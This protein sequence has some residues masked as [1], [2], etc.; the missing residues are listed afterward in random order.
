MYVLKYV[1][2]I[3]IT[4]TYPK[5][6]SPEKKKKNMSFMI[7]LPKNHDIRWQPNPLQSWSTRACRFLQPTWND[8]F[9]NQPGIFSK[10]TIRGSSWD[11]GPFWTLKTA[12]KKLGHQ[13]FGGTF[14]FCSKKLK[15]EPKSLPGKPSLDWYSEKPPGRRPQEKSPTHQAM[16]NFEEQNAKA[17]RERQGKGVGFQGLT[18]DMLVVMSAQKKNVPGRWWQDLPGLLKGLVK[19]SEKIIQNGRVQKTQNSWN[20]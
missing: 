10:Q 7:S 1:T 15:I 5:R 6:T 20:F 12:T 2:Y 4:Q 18:V 19:K 9:T 16:G 13:S 17:G 8:Y 3:H 11:L 14:F